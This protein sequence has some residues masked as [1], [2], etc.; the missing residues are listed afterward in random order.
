MLLDKGWT[1]QKISEVLFIDDGTIANY[2]RRY[3][4]G[5]IEE[6]L[7]DHYQGGTH[8]ISNDELLE[9][10]LHLTTIIYQNTHDICE[11]VKKKYR[12]SYTLSG[13]IALLHRMGF[14]YKK[15]KASLAKPTGK[16]KKILLKH[17]KKS[18]LPMEKFIFLI[19]LTLNI[20]QFFHM[21]G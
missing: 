19:Q 17:M 3:K 9:L 7:D 11:Y 16:I 1:Y 5:G 21:D 2:R 20:I 4:E 12:A 6:L 14:S 15:R 18:N 13:M 8:K 10:Q